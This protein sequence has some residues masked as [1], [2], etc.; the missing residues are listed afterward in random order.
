M[1][2][3]RSDALR[4]RKRILDAARR[5]DQ[6][7]L[8]HNELAK[9]AGVGV[10]TVYRHFPTTHS[11]IEALTQDTLERLLAACETGA[12]RDDPWEGVMDLVDTG[13]VLLL[14]DR[15]LQ[16]VLLSHH[17]DAP[18]V[19]SVKESIAASTQTV[20]SRAHK[21][22]VLRADITAERLQYLMCGLEHALRAA[23]LDDH[24]ALRDVLVAGIRPSQ[25]SA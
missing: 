1:Q 4:S 9:E 20:I 14:E 17:D 10:G 3:L 22:G 25:G 19:R 11:L 5:H 13:L 15:G 2:P 6:G 7:A 16:E 21:A 8:R 23:P 24:G 18:E 12:A